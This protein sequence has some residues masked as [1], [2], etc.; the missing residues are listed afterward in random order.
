MSVPNK[1]PPANSENKSTAP[2][3]EENKQ[4]AHPVTTAASRALTTTKQYEVGPTSQTLQITALRKTTEN[5]AEIILSPTCTEQDLQHVEQSLPSLLKEAAP[6]L[7]TKIQN[8]CTR[9]LQALSSLGKNTNPQELRSLLAEGEPILKELENTPEDHP[10]YSLIQKLRNFIQ[11]AL[12]KIE[13][14][15]IAETATTSSGEKP[16]H[17][18]FVATF[19]LS[20]L[21]I[22][23]ILHCLF[24]KN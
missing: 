14:Q 11:D 3:R 13:T 5:L 1:L 22:Y 4:P 10:S 2:S 20:W 12:G 24:Q 16:S 18:G 15:E 7:P 19:F 17:L 9:C 8:F 6:F 21:C 23:L